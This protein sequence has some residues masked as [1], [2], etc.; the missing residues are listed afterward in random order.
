MHREHGFKASH[1]FFARLQEL[2]ALEVVFRDLTMMDEIFNFSNFS[3][4]IRAL[5][6]IF[7]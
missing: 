7:F 5:G 1:R 3:E 6:G 4:P 2:Q